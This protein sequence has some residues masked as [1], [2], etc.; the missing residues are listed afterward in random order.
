MDLSNL[1]VSVTLEST[2]A[3]LPTH[4]YPAYPAAECT[5]PSPVSGSLLVV[6]VAMRV[7]SKS[8]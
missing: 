2:I 3:N 7:V 6:Y 1:S 5:G 4:I 8:G